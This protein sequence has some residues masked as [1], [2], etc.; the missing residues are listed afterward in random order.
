MTNEQGLGQSFDCPDPLFYLEGKRRMIFFKM[1]K[2]K[3][4]TSLLL[5]ASFFFFVMAVFNNSNLVFAGYDDTVNLVETNPGFESGGNGW[6]TGGGSIDNTQ[7]TE[8]VRSAKLTSDGSGGCDW[9]SNG[10]YNVT[11]GEQYQFTFDYKTEVGAGGNPQV[12]FRFFGGGSFKGEAQRTLGLTNDAW[13]PIVVEAT[14]SEGAEYF[15]IFFSASTFGSYAGSVWFDNT[16]VNPWVDVT[17]THFPPDGS[18]GWSNEL[19]LSWQN[20][21]QASAYLVYLG[22]DLNEVTN[23]QYLFLAG[24]VDFDGMVGISDLNVLVQQWLSGTPSKPGPSADIDLNDDVNNL[25]F[26]RLAKDWI[27][28]TVLPDV[29]QSATY[30]PNYQPDLSLDQDYYWRVDAVVDGQVQSGPV[31]SFNCKDYLDYN[32]AA[33]TQVFY[34]EGSDLNRTQQVM[35]QTLQGLV[36]RVK[37]AL[38]IRGDSNQ[39]W[40]DDLNSQ[41]GVNKTSINAIGGQAGPVAWAL[42]YFASY[43]DSYILFDG[44]DGD[45]LTAAINLAAALPG[46]IAVDITDQSLMTSRSVPMLYDTRGHDE[47]WV[48]DQFSDDFTKEAIFVQRNDITQHGA[49]LRDL[50]VTLGALTWWH[51]DLS[52]TEEVFSDFKANIPC[53]GWDSSV[54]PGEDNAVTF[55]SNHN[56]YTVP[57]DWML[58]LSLFAGTASIE[59]EIEFTQPCS[60]N[61]YTP[62]DNVHYVSFCMSDMDNANTIFSANGWAQH[63]ERYGNSHRGEF[64]MGWGMPPIMMKIG[65][66][67]MKWWYDQA[68]ESDC[69]IGYC[70]GLDYF[71][72]SQFPELEL[73]MSHLDKYLRDADL[74]TMCILDNYSGP[75]TSEAYKTGQLYG[76]LDSLRGMFLGYDHGNGAIAW[77]NG[78]PLVTGRY[79]LWGDRRQGVCDN[80]V[81]LAASI[82]ALPAD[83]YSEDGYTFV[84]VHAWSYGWDEVATC[85]DNLDS[86]V[87][88]V[89]P[90]ELIEQIYLHD[91]G[92]N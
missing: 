65:P 60:D 28:S 8:G 62:E 85:I 69:F 64:P 24:D 53:Y 2:K 30:S 76:Q 5:F 55:H 79:A 86:N 39:L 42:D 37:P 92:P 59:P 18:E 84:I 57:T 75:L 31:R 11:P 3:S 70:S 4:S 83:P 47:K 90:N 16:A 34:L 14:C 19:T 49:F 46:S 89:T 54:A 72:P 88:V 48:W 44:N 36:A 7:A 50:P 29:F 77:F 78:K 80:G 17:N 91:L 67:V 81:N 45:S 63:P 74:S 66:T 51:D 32:I 33:P 61:T 10:Y 23:A 25:D 87:R 52:E 15:D 20:N 58:N 21:D 41:Y 35:F 43:Y 71:H 56:M 27:G 9:R 22:T 38:F 12:R 6:N 82:N 13:Q 26:S 1:R 73:H 68:Y 40:L